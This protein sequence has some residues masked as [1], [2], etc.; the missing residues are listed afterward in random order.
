MIQTPRGDPYAGKGG[1]GSTRY[2]PAPAQLPNVRVSSAR[3][4]ELVDA[5]RQHS[6]RYNQGTF[7]KLQQWYDTYRGVWKGRLAAFRNNVSIPFTFAM[8]QSDVARKV[9]SSFGSWPIVS[10]E[11]YAPEDRA[12]AKK[13]EVLISAQMKDADSIIKACDFFLSAD[14]CGT[15]IARYGWKNLTRKT[16]IRR[17]EQVAPGYSVPVV[18]E[19]DAEMFNGPDWTTVDRLD[20]WQQPGKIR[21]SDMAWAIHRY[22]VDLDDLINDAAGPNPYFDPQAVEALRSYP[23][24]GTAA[25]EFAQRRVTYRT[26]YDYQARQSERFSKPVEIWEMHGYVPAEFAPDGIRFRC[27]AVGNGRVV[28]KNREGAMGN[29]QMP[30]VTYCPMPDPYSFDGVAKTEIAFG[31]QQTANRLANQKLDALDSLIDPMYVASAGANINTQH[32]FTRAGRIILVDG[33]ADESNIRALVPNM[34]GLNAAY[35]EIGQLFQM[36]QL[37]TGETESLM[38]QAGPARETARGFLGRQENALTRLAMETRL[39]EEGFIEPLAD[40]FRHMDR[41]WLPLPQEIKILGSIATTD[42]DTGLPYH[43]V[44][45]QI[46]Y[47]DLVP[48]Y[49]ARA[50]GASQMMGRSVRQQNLVALLQMM[51]SNPALLQLVNWGNFARQAFDLFDFT[52]VDDLL[53]QKV[54]AVNQTAEQAGVSPE[55]VATMVSSSLDQMDP[56]VLGRLMQT[57][58]TGK[59][60]GTTN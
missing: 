10:F 51:S 56:Q 4:I 40:A 23:L 11:G 49:R 3:I 24:E 58:N 52:N 36:M 50:V 35:T 57:A 34:S 5:R 1:P 48:D 25:A 60:P 43:A 59:M 44:N 15:G 46:D 18:R 12:R 47:D 29:N 8:I 27:I 38:G 45:E 22:W 20:F 55:S 54:P 41:L 42:P 31:P 30:F 19:Y 39:A 32:L 21:L 17:L 26:Q 33:A 14:I 9:Q 28:M 37:G 53:V 16:R 13:N 6:Q 2:S 7:T